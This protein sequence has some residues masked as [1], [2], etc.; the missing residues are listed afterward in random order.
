[1]REIPVHITGY[2]LITLVAVG[3]FWKYFAGEFPD[4]IIAPVWLWIV[5]AY[6]NNLIARFLSSRPPFSQSGEGAR[7]R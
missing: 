1:M 7:N 4:W 6:L 5:V 3:S 2:F